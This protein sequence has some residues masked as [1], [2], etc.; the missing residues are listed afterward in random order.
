MLPEKRPKGHLQS[1]KTQF[2]C[3]ATSS[4]L[5]LTKGLYL[6][7]QDLRRGIELMFFAYRDF[8]GGADRPVRARTGPSA[9][10]SDIFCWP[11]TEYECV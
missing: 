4:S 9:S 7:K 5:R 10:P 2:Y 6:R 8:T 11:A 3:G 1:D